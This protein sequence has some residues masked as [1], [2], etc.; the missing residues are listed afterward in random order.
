MNI[1][2]YKEINE[3]TYGKFSFSHDSIKK[4]SYYKYMEIF[5][6]CEN[7]FSPVFRR[8]MD[9]AFHVLYNRCVGR[10]LMPT[11]ALDLDNIYSVN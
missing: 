2:D 9:M 7:S 10:V 1:E 8:H 3:Q 5:L 4:G 11:Y 6:L